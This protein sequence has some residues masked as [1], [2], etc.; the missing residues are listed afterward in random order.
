[1]LQSTQ[2]NYVAVRNDELYHFG[3]KGMKW[4][5]RRYQNADGTYTAEGKKRYGIDDSGI[6]TK[7]GKKLEKMDR[8]VN[9]AS[10]DANMHLKAAKANALTG[11]KIK[12]ADKY[13]LAKNKMS[14]INYKASKMG[15]SQKDIPS[16]REANNSLVDVGKYFVSKTGGE[17]AISLIP[18]VVASVGMS[19][20]MQAS[21][22]PVIVIPRASGSDFYRVNQEAVD[23]ELRRRTN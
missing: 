15:I 12:A 3:V 13:D 5:V 4:G 6:K 14:K 9:K 16:L 11:K 23:A 22:I 2:N 21:G 10:F 17:T 19:F 20:A 18:K 7:A 1:M 8:W